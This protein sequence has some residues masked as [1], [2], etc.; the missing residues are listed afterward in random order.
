MYF[1]SIFSQHYLLKSLSFFPCFALT[2]LLK[3]V[4]YIC[5]GLFLG[6]LFSS[7]DLCLFF[8]LDFC[9]FMALPKAV[10]DSLSTAQG[11]KCMFNIL[12]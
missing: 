4:G 10:G 11:P 9:S 1:A 12:N 7:T 8:C 6:S 5:M 3:S 2:P